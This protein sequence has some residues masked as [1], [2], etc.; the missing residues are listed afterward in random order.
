MTFIYRLWGGL[1]TSW[2]VR[3]SEQC[4]KVQFEATNQ[5]YIP[6]DTLDP[7]LL[8]LFINDL[9]EGAECTLSKFADDTRLGG[10]GDTPAGHAAIQR[11]LNRLEK[12]AYRNLMGFSRRIV[13]SCTRG[14]SKPCTSICWGLSSWK[15]T[16]QKRT[17]GPL[18]QRRWMVSGAALGRSVSNRSREVMLSPA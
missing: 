3:C 8:Q 6:G 2:R 15:A 18:Q 7:V 14:G 17:W 4:H 10:V 1:K 5:W 9:N 12:W 16:C 13:K 11:D